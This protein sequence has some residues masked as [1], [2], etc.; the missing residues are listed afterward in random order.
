M[1]FLFCWSADAWLPPQWA[2]IAGGAFHHPV[3][4]PP[5]FGLKAT[6]EARW[7]PAPERWWWEA[8]DGSCA[9]DWPRRAS[10]W[11]WE[12][13]CCTSRGPSRARCCAWEYW[14]SW[15]FTSAVCPVCRR[16][17]CDNTRRAAPPTRQCCLAA[18]PLVAW[19]NVKVTGHPGLMPWVAYQRQ[20][21]LATWF[22]TLPPLPDKQFSSPY[23]RG[24]RE[25]EVKV[26][27]DARLPRLSSTL[28]MH[29]VYVFIGAVWMQF[30]A[31]GLLLLG[32]PLGAH[33]WPQ[34]VAGASSRY[35]RRRS[36]PAGHALPALHRAVHIRAAHSDCRQ[37]AGALVSHGGPPNAWTSDRRSHGGPSHFSSWSIMPAHC[38]RLSAVGPDS[39][40]P[41]TDIHGRPPSG[42]CQL[43]GGSICRMG[44][45]CRGYG[46]KPGYFCTDAFGP[47]EPE[48]AGSLPRPNRVARNHRSAS[49]SEV[50]WA[51][52][53]A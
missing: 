15:R 47:R 22:W 44:L 37:R 32:V 28:I 45:Q 6:G 12:G 18:A 42:I 49:R 29:L 13:C 48:A 52:Y 35:W 26:Y 43:P 16:Q 19:Y 31:F 46:N 10:A 8:W 5:L 24:R 21:D 41:A 34:K 36:G 38:T 9:E 17:A 27:Q 50:R 39:H 14:W 1:V 7:Q 11:A 23:L 40:D 4:R 3:L 2:L 25:A 33:A 51:P 20:Y 30:L 53:P